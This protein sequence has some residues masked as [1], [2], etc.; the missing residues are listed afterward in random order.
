MDQALGRILFAPREVCHAALDG[1]RGG[2]GEAQVLQKRKR[3]GEVVDDLCPLQEK[4][5]RLH[6]LRGRVANEHLQGER[7]EAQGLAK[8]LQNARHGHRVVR[9]LIRVAVLRARQRRQACENA[10]QCVPG[11]LR[12]CMP[13]SE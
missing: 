3:R 11:Q 4:R 10:Y 9:R 5:H 12:F 8:E 1:D 6:R 13:N 7:G 2:R